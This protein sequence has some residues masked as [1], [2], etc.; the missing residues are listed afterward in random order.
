MLNQVMLQQRKL[1]L[2]LS[3]ARS[4]RNKARLVEVDKREQMQTR[5]KLMGVLVNSLNCDIDNRKESILCP[6]LQQHLKLFRLV[7]N[8]GLYFLSTELFDLPLTSVTVL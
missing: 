1:V 3:T 2:L 5:N 7:E 4:H 8:V 6:L